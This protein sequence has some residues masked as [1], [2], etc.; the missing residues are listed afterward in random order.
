[1]GKVRTELVKRISA[2]LV[3]K[4]PRSFTSEFEENKQFL[5]EIGLDVSKKLR[6]RLAGY[7]S[8]IMRIR[9]GS[10]P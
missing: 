4:Y 10:T 2:E 3:E 6:N 8:G 5:R 1:M 9:Q 7:I